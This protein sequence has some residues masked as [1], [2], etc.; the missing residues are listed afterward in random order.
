MTC[1]LRPLE[2]DLSSFDHNNQTTDPNDL[3]QPMSPGTNTI[4][5][6][7][8]LMS[9]S[10]QNFNS[11]ILTRPFS[12]VQYTAYHISKKAIN[13]VTYNEEDHEI[14]LNPDNKSCIDIRH[15]FSSQKKLG[16]PVFI[17]EKG[18]YYEGPWLAN[19]PHGFGKEQYQNGNIRYHGFFK[20]GEYHGDSIEI[21]DRENRL[22]YEGGMR[23]GKFHGKGVLYKLGRSSYKGEFSNGLYNGEGESYFFNGF[24]KYKGVWRCG[25]IINGK[26]YDR[27]GIPVYSG[28]FEKNQWDGVGVLVGRVGLKCKGFERFSN[29]SKGKKVGFFGEN[30]K[31][32]ARK[33]QGFGV[34][35]ANNAK[36][37]I[38][39]VD[40]EYKNKL[41]ENYLQKKKDIILDLPS[42]CIEDSAKQEI[43]SPSMS[44]ADETIN[45]NDTE[46]DTSII[47]I[48]SMLENDL[49]NGLASVL[50]EDFSF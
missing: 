45:D 37:P 46:C 12:C 24:K 6:A 27:N 13:L 39:Y 40:Y 25:K 48:K 10:F 17:S 38:K 43:S 49:T 16:V 18:V 30:G 15:Q 1:D 20:K 23:D 2:L 14:R 3:L 47:N 29:Y 8:I 26:E 41:I 4:N 22:L 19:L 33:Y 35:F 28:N 44:L 32:K 36:M 11:N 42:A 9:S 21:Y 50:D 5:R 34:G 7:R 31:L